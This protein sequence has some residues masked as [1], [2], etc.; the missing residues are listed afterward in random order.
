VRSISFYIEESVMLT[1]FTLV[2]FTTIALASTPGGPP[3]PM[4]RIAGREWPAQFHLGIVASGSFSTP[5]EM[6]ADSYEPYYGSS[7]GIGLMMSPRGIDNVHVGTHYVC[8]SRDVLRLKG[9]IA[10]EFSVDENTEATL[11]SLHVGA[12]VGEPL[13]ASR[14]FVLTPYMGAGAG[15]ARFSIPDEAFNN[16]GESTRSELGREN[17][18][19]QITTYRQFG[20]IISGLKHVSLQYSYDLTNVERTWV[21]FHSMVSGTIS[22]IIISGVPGAL[23]ATVAADVRYLPAFRLAVLAYQVAAAYLWY[24]FDYEHHNWPFDDDPPLKYHR[25]KVS[26]NYYF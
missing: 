11:S 8:F 12:G 26:L 16:F 2:C 17:R 14:Y 9:S 18:E 6:S 25:Q 7:L 10:S 24:N 5:R 4:I 22:N 19:V 15:G 3:S 21:V 1:I 23:S 13:I 20:I